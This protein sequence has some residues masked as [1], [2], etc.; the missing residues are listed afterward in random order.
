MNKVIFGLLL[1]VSILGMLL[2][3]LN[4][5]FQQD[6]PPKFSQFSQS[7]QAGPGTSVPP[8]AA[9]SGGP[10]VPPSSKAT[11]GLPNL[12][13]P[14]DEPA[15]PPLP[16]PREEK[17]AAP[18][19]A[20]EAAT[21]IRPETFAAETVKSDTTA[22]SRPES[23]S[24]ETVPPPLPAREQTA[25]NASAPAPQKP[26]PAAT[27]RA[28]V[29]QSDKQSGKSA[30]PRAQ[31]A[32]PSLTRFV[33]FARDTGA[34]VR[35]T[36]N[37]PIRYSYM[38]LEN[39]PRVVVDLEGVWQMAVPG[40]PGNPMVSKVRVGNPEGKTRVVIDLKAKPRKLRMVHA[41][42][43]KTLDVRLDK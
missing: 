25:R 6:A 26:E 5:R 13:L 31:T 19:A 42:D 8:P 12:P 17:P 36:G 3:M 29:G 11:Q 16:L 30:T 40:V 22:L 7:S 28:T 2:I 33:V 14:P 23:A 43:R 21:P 32:T 10:V 39:P 9:L 20:P 35:M 38:S 34:T 15:V 27:G 4:A 41:A 18:T 1:A 24:A 37:Q